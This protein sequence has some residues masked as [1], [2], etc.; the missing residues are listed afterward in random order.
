MSKPIANFNFD[1][2]GLSAIFTDSSS[3]VP[4][5]WSWNFGFKEG[6]VQKISTLQNPG[7]IIFP[8]AGVYLISLV[9]ANNDGVS[10]PKTFNLLVNSTPTLSLTIAEMVKC[11]LP[12]GLA[13]DT[14]CFKNSIKKWQLYLQPKLEIDDSDVFN[15]SLWPPVANV[16]ISK[17][18]VYEIMLSAAKSSMANIYIAMKLVS[19]NNETT[20]STVQVANY[21]YDLPEYTLVSGD[22]LDVDNFI[23][24]G[25]SYT[26]NNKASWQEVVDWM[27]T[28]GKGVFILTDT[29]IVSNGN[30]NFISTFNTTKNISSGGTE[31][32]NDSFEMT[33]LRIENISSIVEVTGEV[34][35]I[36]P[37]SIKYLETGPSKTEWYDSSSFW[38][39][40]FGSKGSSDSIMQTVINDICMWAAQVGIRLPMC[41]AIPSNVLPSFLVSRNST[42]GC[43]CYSNFFR[44]GYD[45]P[46]SKG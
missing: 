16:L 1:I 40:M 36:P 38:S 33:E 24:N 20:S 23:I 21:T 29:A 14:L 41:P 45:K 6:E 43:N 31:A 46:A 5:S 15:E 9:V 26:T 3:G 35:D 28:L 25:I 30:Y 8:T 32:S 4:T 22:T 27:N 44:D 12:A 39:S 2:N 13:L 17:L 11:D 42:K 18:I 7:E 37:G 19:M 34:P 10:D